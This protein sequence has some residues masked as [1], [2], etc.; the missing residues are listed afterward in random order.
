KDCISFSPAARSSLSLGQQRS[1]SSSKT[2][3]NVRSPRRA[4]TCLASVFK[5]V[6][7]DE[8]IV[9]SS[10]STSRRSTWW[11][12][13][14]LFDCLFVLF[15]CPRIRSRAALLQLRIREIL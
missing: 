14:K 3:Q 5:S 15:P 13:R 6:I 10:V 4:A 12:H 9:K 7:V 11:Q 1:K 8:D 2:T